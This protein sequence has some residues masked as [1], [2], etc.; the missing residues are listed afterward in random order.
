MAAPVEAP[1]GVSYAIRRRIEREYDR[2]GFFDRYGQDVIVALVITFFALGFVFSNEFKGWIQ[3]IKADWASKRYNPF[4]MPFA[5]KVHRRPG[6]TEGGA[7]SEN[8]SGAIHSILNIIVQMAMVPISLIFAIIGEVMGAIMDAISAIR[9]MFDE[10]RNALANII[11]DIVGKFLNVTVEIQKYNLSI[12]D[13]FQRLSGAIAVAALAGTSG[14]FTMFSVALFFTTAIV[15]VLIGLAAVMVVLVSLFS[16]PF[17]NIAAII[18]FVV[19]VVIFILILIPFIMTKKVL[20]NVEDNH[21]L[22]FHPAPTPSAPKMPTCFSGD[23]ELHRSADGKPVYMKDV[24]VGDALEGCGRVTA[25]MELLS[26]G[27]EIVKLGSVIVTGNHSV[28]HPGLGWIPASRHPDAQLIDDFTEDRVYCIS[29]NT[30]RLH[31]GGHEFG[32]WDDLDEADMEKLT[33]DGGPLPANAGLEDV[34]PLLLSGFSQGVM[35]EQASG[36]P[37]PIQHVKPGDELAKGGKCVGV[38]QLEGENGSLLHHLVVE[39]GVCVVDGT[40]CDHYDHQIE[41]YL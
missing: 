22:F 14:F 25:T 4:Y 30:K 23:T 9:R 41:Q 32:D 2:A 7:V 24:K 33:R 40:L 10:V 26:E 27:Q 6:Q 16:I 3:R 13:V 20:N 39:G 37:R 17:V 8:F 21:R 28:R 15:M 18:L 31:I 38:V 36:E 34:H 5:G 12:R 35:V 1:S 19:D 29:T 11:K